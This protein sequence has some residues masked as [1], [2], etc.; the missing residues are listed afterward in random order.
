MTDEQP[1][2]ES[3]AVQRPTPPPPP[4]A[5]LSIAAAAKRNGDDAF[6]RG[7]LEEVGMWRTVENYLREGARGVAYVPAD[8]QLIVAAALALV[9]S[10]S[11]SGVHRARR[12]DDR[13]GK[14]YIPYD[15]IL[16]LIDS[17]EGAFPGLI[18]QYSGKRLTA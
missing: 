4:E 13:G 18:D 6:I 1:A 11:E 12:L 8:V 16:P 9:A 3:R 5:F 14:A 17:L 2:E 7:A 15:L 10:A